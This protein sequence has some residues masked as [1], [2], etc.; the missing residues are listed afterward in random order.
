ML[1]RSLA[2]CLTDLKSP[3]PVPQ[4]IDFSI[5]LLGKDTLSV[6]YQP[7]L[8]IINAMRMHNSF[9][10]N[11]LNF[12]ITEARK[13]FKNSQNSQ[14][15]GPVNW[16]KTFQNYRKGDR[17]IIIIEKSISL[18]SEEDKKLT[19]LVVIEF[20]KHCE[21]LL[22]LIKKFKLPQT[23]FTSKAMKV[24][25]DIINKINL[26]SNYDSG[27]IENKLPLDWADNELSY[28]IKTFK[29]KIL[30]VFEGYNNEVDFFD[31]YIIQTKHAFNK[32]L[33]HIKLCNSIFIW[34]KNYISLSTG[35]GAGSHLIFMQ[36]RKIANLFEIWCFM[37]MAYTLLQCDQSELVQKSLLKRGN[38]QPLFS[39]NR[40]TEVY[41]NFYGDQICI[42]ENSKILRN[43]HI[44]WFFR[45]KQDYSKSIILDTKYKKWASE[46]NL[47]V[48]GYMNDFGVNRGIV[49]FSHTIPLERYKTKNNENGLIVCNFGRN[50]EKLFCALTLTPEDH[51]IEANSKTLKGL[52]S[53]VILRQ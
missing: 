10:H 15:T 27:Y 30:N 12:I 32:L 7:L 1:R 20:K 28:P 50:N 34:R 39:L 47:K 45:N 40:Q 29:E 52:I 14:R 3:L 35:L 51:A 42:Y 25:A 18:M 33:P 43:S 31:T 16:G 22:L 36:T 17:T 24:L 44:E 19:A 41:Y 13:P 5:D 4:S 23:S 9:I 8:L 38:K 26:F 49:I 48:L 37:E 6:I 46:D 2:I 21:I 11:V 53:E